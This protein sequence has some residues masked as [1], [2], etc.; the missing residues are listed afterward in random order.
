[1]LAWQSNTFQINEIKIIKKCIQIRKTFYYNNLYSTI[2]F[3]DILYYIIL[4]YTIYV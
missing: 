2:F 3:D 1:V 4:Y